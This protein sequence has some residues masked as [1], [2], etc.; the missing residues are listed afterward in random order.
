MKSV[1]CQSQSAGTTRALGYKLATRLQTGGTIF[2]QGELGAG[3]TTLVQGMAEGFAI[4]TN[5]TSPTFTIIAVYEIPYHP[6]LKRLV[7]VD[8]YRITYLDQ[9]ASLDIPQY[10]QDPTTVLMVEWPER[11]LALWHHVIGKIAFSSSDFNHR[12]LTIEGSI[13]DLMN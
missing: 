10:E 1:V 12:Q 5:I 7:H 11:D 13:A 6:Y 2:L 3:K 4:A 9:I 8:L